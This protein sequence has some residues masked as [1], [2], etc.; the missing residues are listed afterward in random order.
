M[1]K[2]QTSNALVVLGDKELTYS[3][4]QLPKLQTAAL[5]QI[6]QIRQLEREGAARAVLAGLTLHRVKA[7]VKFGQFLPWL[8]ANVKGVGYA[9]CNFY[10]RLAS[11]FV[12]KMHVRKP[13]IL[14]LPGDQTNL[15]LDDA[16]GEARVFFAKLSDFVGER[17]LNELL[18]KYDIKSAPKLGGA[19]EPAADDTPTEP[20]TP[21]Q[22][23]LQARDEIGSVISRAETLFLHENRLQYLVGHPEEIKGVATSLRAL[24][25]KIED[26]AKD[27]ASATP[28]T[29]AA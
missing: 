22:L 19:R 27:L 8:K 23:Y 26:A 13:D 14:A 17:S 7:S 10:M 25:D 3:Q 6:S 24:A 20:P 21:D 18:D 15:A 5:Q 9:Q 11:V 28:T 16:N 4:E 12:E 2:K 1:S 29:A